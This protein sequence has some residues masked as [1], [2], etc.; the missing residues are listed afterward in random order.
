MFLENHLALTKQYQ[1]K[2]IQTYTRKIEFFCPSLGY[3][4]DE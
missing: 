1:N 3:I 4:Y 2:R